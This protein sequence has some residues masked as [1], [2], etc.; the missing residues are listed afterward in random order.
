MLATQSLFGSVRVHGRT[1]S[2]SDFS[3]VE[4]RF[5]IAEVVDHYA[6]YPQHSPSLK[7]D[8]GILDMYIVIGRGLEA[9]SK[10]YPNISSNTNKNQFLFELIQSSAR[11]QAVVAPSIKKIDSSYKLLSSL[12][13]H[14]KSSR[15]ITQAY[16]SS[17][18]RLSAQS[19]HKKNLQ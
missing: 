11:I 9:A 4:A 8:N 6:F 12:K 16:S 1:L 19:M 18:S 5:F 13:K 17:Y 14:N 2:S 3:Y 15:C 7:L 10:S